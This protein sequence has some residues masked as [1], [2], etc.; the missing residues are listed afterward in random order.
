MKKTGESDRS[1]RTTATK[2]RTEKKTATAVPNPTAKTAGR[3]LPPITFRA[4]P[5]RP[6]VVTP[7]GKAKPRIVIVD[8]HPIARQGIRLLIESSDDLCVCG[9][10]ADADGALDA[11]ANFKPDLAVVDLS[12]NGKPGLEL[13]KDL[14]SM[15][16]KLPI[17]V[18]SMHDETM[19]AERAL[20]A[21][22]RGYIQKQEATDKIL[23]AIRRIL[24]GEIYVSDAIAGRVLRQLA[25]GGNQPLK[26]SLELLSDRE[27]EVF[28]FLGQGKP[29]REIASI[30][31]LSAKT[32]EAHREHIKEKLNFASSNE[33][34]RYAIQVGMDK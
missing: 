29:V 9:E 33:L 26:S 22:A 11:V 23:L 7:S 5:G 34:L 15:H 13:I 18:L 6:T 14:R 10:A 30:L 28:G 24:A 1:R 21:G 27:L 8:D 17:L 32:V 19:Y 3:D 31:H 20:R 2:D 4:K 16:E 25:G 12:L